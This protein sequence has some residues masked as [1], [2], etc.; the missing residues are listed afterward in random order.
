M[1]A[2]VSCALF[3]VRCLLCVACCSLYLKHW[4]LLVAGCFLLV[5][6][7]WLVGCSLLSIDCR[8]LTTV[9]CL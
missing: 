1:L 8:V 2:G 7:L 6:V 9:C 3:A 4:L 5:D